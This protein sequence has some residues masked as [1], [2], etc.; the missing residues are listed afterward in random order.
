MPHVQ[1][2]LAGF[3]HPDR[4]PDAFACMDVFVAPYIRPSTETFALTVVE[5]MAMGVPVVHFDIGGMRVSALLCCCADA[6]YCFAL[7]VCDCIALRFKIVCE[8][9]LRNEC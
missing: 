9:C 5:A 7:F 6:W 4:V 1:L 8:E 3:V 2:L